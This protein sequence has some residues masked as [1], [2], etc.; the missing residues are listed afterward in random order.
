MIGA[1][2]ENT[3][4][5]NFMK[6]YGVLIQDLRLQGNGPFLTILTPIFDFSYKLFI[7]IGVTLLVN[8]PTLTILMFNFGM[9]LYLQ[10]ILL[11]N[12]YV[13]RLEATRLVFNALCY[14]CLNYHLLTLT[15]FV[16]FTVYPLISNSVICL[17]LANLLV[18]LLLVLYSF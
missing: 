11:A 12:P 16:N 3:Q 7:A 18:N 17:V 1:L 5:K 13:E 15:D 10:F 14:L 2:L 6:T 9:I 8:W 4:H